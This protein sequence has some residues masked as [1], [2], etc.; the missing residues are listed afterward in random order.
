MILFFHC[1]WGLGFCFLTFHSC[2]TL[3]AMKEHTQPTI[4]P[5]W[6]LWENVFNWIISWRKREGQSCKSATLLGFP[7]HLEDE[8]LIHNGTFTVKSQE[9][10]A[11]GI[12]QWQ[13]YS[14]GK[15]A[16]SAAWNTGQEPT[17]VT[18]W[19]VE[20]NTCIERIYWSLSLI[21]LHKGGRSEQFLFASLLIYH[22]SA[23]IHCRLPKNLS[24][25]DCISFWFFFVS[26]PIFLQE[27][28]NYTALTL[29]IR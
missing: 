2:C 28:L 1:Y 20:R 21:G 18:L 29:N 12:C 6:I 19:L 27:K 15:L 17:S 26:M 8:F 11:S 13:A 24:L 9:Q 23:V 4:H 10:A 22:C 7:L 5:C 16:V 25:L 14:H 3:I